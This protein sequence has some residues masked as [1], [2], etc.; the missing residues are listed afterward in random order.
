MGAGTD[1]GG[2]SRAAPLGWDG[3]IEA[4]EERDD[5]VGWWGAVAAADAAADD[6]ALGAPAAVREFL[7]RSAESRSCRGHISVLPLDHADA[8][9][10]WTACMCDG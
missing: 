10:V 6:D 8:A 5:V 3:M 4:D 9:E 2:A 7:Y 1:V